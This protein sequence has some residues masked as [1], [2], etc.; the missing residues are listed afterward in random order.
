MVF[1]ISPK[2]YL[3]QLTEDHYEVCL[4]VHLGFTNIQAA[5]WLAQGTFR[6]LVGQHGYQRPNVGNR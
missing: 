3:K 2:I 6:G 4:C 1:Q 5:A